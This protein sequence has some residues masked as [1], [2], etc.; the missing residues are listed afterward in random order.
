[1]TDFWETWL[2]IEAWSETYILV[3]VES[4]WLYPSLFIFT[5]LDAFIP[6]APAESLVIAVSSSWSTIG[7]GVFEFNNPYLPAIILASG[8]GAWCG[9]QIAYLIG[10]KI[11]VRNLRVFRT[12]RGIRSLAWAE[13]SLEKRGTTFIIAGRHI[14]MGRITVNL[15]AGALRFPHKR[16]MGVDALAV[17]IWVLW[18]VALGTFAGA[19]IDNLLLAVVAGV[20]GGI[21]MGVIADKV[22]SKLGLS[23][24]DLPDLTEGLEP[25][26]KEEWKKRKR[27]ARTQGSA[28]KVKTKRKKKKAKAKQV[29]ARKN[30]ALRRRTARRRSR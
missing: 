14:P 9:D 11:D 8:L 30:R 17:G 3:F 16:F 29:K 12:E 26:D 21:A 4:F 25:V 24:V 27:E 19:F 13:R 18:N 22:L 6:M 2:G 28:A 23:P 20:I 15:M 10:S 7:Y 5:L 1:M